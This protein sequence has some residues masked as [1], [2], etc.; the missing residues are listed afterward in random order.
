MFFITFHFIFK[1]TMISFI[2]QYFEIVAD[3]KGLLINN[4]YI[5]FRINIIVSM[6]SQG[7]L[8]KYILK[9]SFIVVLQ[10]SSVIDK[11]PF[12]LK[13]FGFLY[14]PPM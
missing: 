11:V 8:E 9:F 12:H 4:I 13:V 10:V 3:I 14:L 2:F 7:C 1:K 5:L 6:F